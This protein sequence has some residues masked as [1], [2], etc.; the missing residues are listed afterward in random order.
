MTKASAWLNAFRLRTL[1]LALSSILMGSML[2][3]Y[4]YAFQIKVLI[5][6]AIT[7]LFLQ[8]LSNLANDYGDTVN[9]ADHSGRQGPQRMV[10]S[11][12]IS[13]REMRMA[14]IVFALLSLVSGLFL[15]YT[16][17]QNAVSIHGLLFFALGI[18][19][20]AAAMKYTMGKNPYGYKGMG[21]VFVLLF[22]GIIGVGG[23]F[24]L[25]TGWVS[26]ITLLPA[27]AV[28]MLSAG[29]LNLNNMRDIN[30]DREAG[31]VT[32]VVRHGMTWAKGYQYILVAGAILFLLFFVCI[33]G[34]EIGHL[35]FVGTLPFFIRH[36]VVVSKATKADD[37]DPELKKLALSTLLLVILFG[38]GLLF[39]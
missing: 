17:F 6:A 11:G 37:F 32:L 2:A 10:Q 16:A 12:A 33:S 8:I 25:H 22:F 28:G 24:Y 13:P 9:G 5:G 38:C 36:L 4:Y 7:T 30:S 18:G 23:S 14:I 27:L 15:I 3:A 1:P 26:W 29:V 19:A 31:K 20:I 21:D 35:L 34:C 39:F